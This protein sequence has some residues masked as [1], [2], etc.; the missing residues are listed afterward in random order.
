MV[1]AHLN[2]CFC[3]FRIELLCSTRQRQDFQM[4]RMTLRTVL[5]LLT[6]FC[7][8]H[9][10][11][12]STSTDKLI[13]W[14]KENSEIFILLK[15]WNE[16]PLISTSWKRL[17]DNPQVIEDQRIF[18]EALESMKSLS[19]EQVRNKSRS[20]TV[21]SLSYIKN[22]SVTEEH[23]KSLTT[24][25]LNVTNKIKVPLERELT[26]LNET[27]QE[28]LGNNSEIKQTSVLCGSR[29]ESE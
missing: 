19:E 4:I 9:R 8:I 3:C 10:A 28:V 11:E 6:N 16:L 1:D 29:V 7:L 17:K 18:L 27:C 13:T 2:Q 21:D 5:L 20:A 22:D 24:N 23:N 26:T 14:V 12:F 25:D 15:H